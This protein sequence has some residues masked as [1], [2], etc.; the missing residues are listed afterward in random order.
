MCRYVAYVGEPL[1]LS[2]ILYEPANGLVHQASDA[3]ESRT[4]I[5]ADGFGIGSLAAAGDDE[6]CV[7]LWWWLDGN[8]TERAIAPVQLMVEGLPDKPGYRWEMY[9]VDDKDSNF[10]AGTDRRELTVAARGQLEP[11]ARHF[12]LNISL[13]LYGTQMV[14]L[15]P[16]E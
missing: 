4:R 8:G 10:A 2:E 3:M 7:I 15:I 12:V 5:N 6:V 9:A 1:L 11:Y 16:N 14:R 13:P